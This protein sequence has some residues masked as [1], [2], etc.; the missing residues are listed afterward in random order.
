MPSRAAG[1]LDA[2]ALLYVALPSAIFLWGWIAWP[3]GP[4][5]AVLLL[6]G[7]CREAVRDRTSPV[8]S[9]GTARAMGLV[10]IAAIWCLLGG[11]GHVVY[12]NLDWPVRDAVLVDL[13]RRPWPVTYDLDGVLTMMRAP[14]GYFLPAATVGGLL[15][16][17]AAEWVLFA[18]TVAGV[19]LTFA[20]LLRDRPSTGSAL[21]RIVVFMLF[22]G[23]DIVGQV[24]H[25]KPH[26]V[27]EHLEWWA[28]LFQYSS[29]T[30][31][32]FWVP[33]HAIPGWV[34]TAWLL[35]HE[36]KRVPIGP[37]ILFVVLT[38][39]WSPLT[40]LGLAPLI[41]VAILARIRD[42]GLRAMWPT[43]A[44]W[45]VLAPVAICAV[46]IVPYLVVGASRVSSGTGASLRFVG[47]DIVPRYIEFVVF[48]FLGFALILLNRRRRDPVLWAS[49]V[50]LLLL[51]T[52]RFGPANDLAMRASIPA[53][54]VLAIHAGR[55]LSSP[56]AWR[57]D[58]GSAIVAL[59]LV[60]IGAVTPAMEFARAFLQPA[61]PMNRDAALVDVTRGTH[62][63]TERH[64]R[65]AD[66]FLRDASP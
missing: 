9:L 50:V 35:G 6:A 19:S 15:G 32:L 56:R 46:L 59:V 3:L 53:L 40:A 62:Y 34:A 8:G 13:V 47:E 20:L 14:I 38:P 57:T 10:A 17:R 2:G 23:M 25:F 58:T 28:Y 26:G 42:E 51:P 60:T 44:N 48:E 7:T 16:I 22:S 37:A 66:T 52:V 64:G 27:G 18:W 45:R 24:T 61:W 63:L 36:P 1:G 29:H 39:L 49:V 5:A 41:G 55:L 4:L 54:A 43:W 65:W 11:Q 21:V 12:A 30:T 31:Q 33:N